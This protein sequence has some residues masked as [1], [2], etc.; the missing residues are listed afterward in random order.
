M[1]TEP[2]DA[3]PQP[4][5][6][7]DLKRE[8]ERLNVE[9]LLLRQRTEFEHLLMEDRE[10]R[11]K[12]FSQHRKDVEELI[13]KRLIRLAGLGFVVVGLAWFS[14]LLPI[15]RLVTQRLD[16][17]FASANIRALIA[18]EA[19]TAAGVQTKGMMENI[20][21]P[22][23]ETALNQIQRESANVTQSAQQFQGK[24]QSEVGQIRGELQSE[25]TQE[26]Q[27]LGSLRQE[28]TAEL[29][30]L[31]ALTDYEEKLKEI[32]L[33]EGAA[34]EGDFGAFQKLS[35]YKSDDHTLV[36]A[37]QA[38]VLES[39]GMYIIG[40]RSKATSIYYQSSAD[41]PK[42]LDD[43]IPTG[44]LESTFLLNQQQTWEARD[45]AADL[46]AGRREL[47]SRGKLALRNAR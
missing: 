11:S 25:R 9:N 41:T 34:V 17:E 12:D 39:K 4:N 2:Q 47:G 46:L 22:A 30:K 31:T 10:K 14:T 3:Q 15:R 40:T 24:T 38:A 29:G 35:A 1:V 18:K 45:K 33:L 13:D 36:D 6:T 20:L 23:I 42:L 16:H 37:A 7:H 5:E 43:K 32:Q 26:K 28:Y 27:S 44:V 19:E 21:K 8:I